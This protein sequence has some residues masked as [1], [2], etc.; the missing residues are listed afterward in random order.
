MQWYNI[1]F[2]WGF[3]GP[4]DRR[5][6]WLT[7]LHSEQPPPHRNSNSH[8]FHHR[9]QHSQ[10]FDILDDANGTA[11]IATLDFG[12]G[13]PAVPLPLAER[14]AWGAGSGPLRLRSG[15]LVHPCVGS[16]HSFVEGAGGYS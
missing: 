2:Y 4:P 1:M 7:L 14:A 10:V 3:I 6:R 11:V 5:G 9:A 13:A 8:R 16:M 15:A 12:D